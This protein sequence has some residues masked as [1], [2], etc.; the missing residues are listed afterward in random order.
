MNLS[1]PVLRESAI[2]A[3]TSSSTVPN[4]KRTVT[5]DVRFFY[6]V[7]NHF[8]QLD[9]RQRCGSVL[10]NGRVVSGSHDST[11]R[12]WNIDRGPCESTLIVHTSF[13]KHVSVLLDGR[14]VS[15]SGDDTLRIRNITT[16]V[17][18][19]VLVGHT[20]SIVSV[21]VLPD[22]RIVSGSADSTLRSW[23]ADAGVCEHVLRGHR[24][25]VTLVILS[26]IL[27]YSLSDFQ[28]TLGTQMNMPATWAVKHHSFDGHFIRP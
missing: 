27:K 9:L 21:C 10:P 24:S 17:C 22:G 5:I 18:D 19:H 14:I 16:G 3:T 25:F 7:K 23:N 26:R 4:V 20:D 2:E 11:L 6:C 8:T 1:P 28:E 15:G 12:I 13:V